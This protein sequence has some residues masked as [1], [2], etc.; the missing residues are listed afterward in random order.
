MTT[1][2]LF[3]ESMGIKLPKSTDGTPRGS[4]D[5]IKA[6]G[7]ATDCITTGEL[8][9]NS[10]VSVLSSCALLPSAHSAA[11]EQLNLEPNEGYKFRHPELKK[12]IIVMMYRGDDNIA[13]QYP[14][15][16]KKAVPIEAIAS[17]CTAVSHSF[18]LPWSFTFLSGF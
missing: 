4:D 17:I 12:A 13:T 10:A 18:S 8:F 14:A 3:A 1:A 11:T 16:C 5:F 9:H 6:T 15:L 7:E 2:T